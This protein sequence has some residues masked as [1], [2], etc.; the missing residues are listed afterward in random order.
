MDRVVAELLVQL[1]GINRTKGN[2]TVL[3]ATNKLESIDPAILR[4]GRFDEKI[5]IPLPGDFARASMFEK[6]LC[7]VP[8]QVSDFVELASASIGLSGAEI[9]F[10]CEKAKQT[11][12]RSIISGSSPDQKITK[13]HIIDAINSIKSA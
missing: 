2:L 6:H 4:P 7:G 1:D 9:A 3:A 10:V 12:I 11:V 8:S 13:E 5:Y